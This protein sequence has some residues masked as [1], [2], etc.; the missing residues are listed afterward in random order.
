[1]DKEQLM[2]LAY[3]LR[4]ET[5]GRLRRIQLWIDQ[6][7]LRS[8]DP[9]IRQLSLQLQYRQLAD[10]GGELLPALPD[11]RW[12]RY[13]IG[14]EDGMLIY[15]FGLIGF[16][17]RRAVDL[18]GGSVRAANT[19]NLVLHHD[20]DVCVIDGNTRSM[21]ILKSFFGRHPSTR[22]RVYPPTCLSEWIDTDTVASLIGDNGFGG[23]VDLLSVDLDGV[24]YWILAAALE[25]V[26]PRVIVVEYQDHLGPD[27]AWTVPYRNDFNVGDYEVNAD[28]AY[29]YC[30]AG[31]RAFDT[32]LA[33]RGYRYVGSNRDGYNAFFV[34]V[35]G[36][37]AIPEVDL[38]EGFTSRW[39]RW[40][41]K[42]R[43]PLVADMDWVKV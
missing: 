35:E 23:E 25:A 6:L 24:D 32:L 28:G 12:D 4:A 27:R 30:G 36:A 18:G 9:T 43:F 14:G 11:A 3:R 31:L 7:P 15:I 5:L 39:T 33:P 2:K 37:E 22:A 1:V 17:D 19:M 34:K 29:L 41:M 38:A 42:H 10:A 40:G 8:S 13:T 26:T 20:F 21:E 16:G